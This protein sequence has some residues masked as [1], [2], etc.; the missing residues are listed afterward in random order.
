MGSRAEYRHETARITIDL[1]PQVETMLDDGQPVLARR[2]FVDTVNTI[3]GWKIRDR[4]QAS[5]T[6]QQA[7]HP[8]RWSGAYY[9]HP[10]VITPELQRK[11][12]HA[13]SLLS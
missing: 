9:S 1:D 4:A 8:D 12:D 3:D 2:L 13:V 11:I 10:F 7:N 6:T 5:V